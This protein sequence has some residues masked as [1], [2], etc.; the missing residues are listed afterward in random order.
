MMILGL[1][2]EVSALRERLDTHERLASAG[3]PATP[4]AVEAYQPGPD[5]ESSRSAARR[6]MIE[7]LT[8]VLLEPEAQ[9]RTGAAPPEPPALPDSTA[10]PR[11]QD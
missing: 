3:K 10:A 11:P 5:V 1:A 9:R 7:C 2:A 8:R 6:A 4:A